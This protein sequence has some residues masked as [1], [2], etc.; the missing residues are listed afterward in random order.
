[1]K[2]TITVTEDE[3][4]D[5]VLL[6][7][8]RLTIDDVRKRHKDL[9]GKAIGMS[10]FRALMFAF[11]GTP[12][13]DIDNKD[14]LLPPNATIWSNDYFNLSA[15]GPLE[16]DIHLKDS[17]GLDEEYSKNVFQGIL[18]SESLEKL[19]GEAGTKVGDL[20]D[21]KR[22]IIDLINE[23]IVPLIWKEANEFMK[24]R[25]EKDPRL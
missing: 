19:I 22:K 13:Y 4:Q 17:I 11:V 23:K 24:K 8:S 6:K 9:A 14:A 10:I 18:C 1:M 21:Q 2:R 15:P 3:Y 12:R 5:F 25:E 20:N 16:C 7:R